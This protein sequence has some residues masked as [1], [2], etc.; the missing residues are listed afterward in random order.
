MNQLMGEKMNKKKFRTALIIVLVIVSTAIGLFSHFARKIIADKNEFMSSNENIYD[1]ML[2]LNSIFIC[3]LFFYVLLD[4]A[5]TFYKDT[6]FANSQYHA[7]LLRMFAGTALF[8]FGLWLPIVF[9]RFDVSL[10]PNL[11]PKKKAMIA[12]LL[13]LFCTFLPF[14][15]ILR[16]VILQFTILAGL[17]KSS[18]TT[19]LLSSGVV[20]AIAAAFFA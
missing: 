9:I 13:G 3:P 6:K 7:R 12:L 2:I 14:F 19:P 15:I 5:K 4:L 16:Q 20:V 1:I 8:V 18:F 11:S 17:F 10:V